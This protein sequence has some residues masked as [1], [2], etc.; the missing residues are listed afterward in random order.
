VGYLADRQGAWGRSARR[1]LPIHGYCGPNGSGKSMVMVYDTI[2]TLE[3]GRPVLSTVRLL[4]YRNPRPCDGGPS[5][6]DPENHEVERM[7]VDLRRSDPDDP[8]SPIIRTVVPTGI[9]DVHQQ[10][11]PLYVRFTDYGQL[12]SWRDGDILMDEVTGVAS[13][14][15]TSSMPVQVANYLVQ[16][17]RRNVA[18]RWSS[19]AWG[20]SDK[21]IREC[22]QG[23]T[24]CTAF[25]PKPAPVDP[26]TGQ[27]AMWLQRR[28]FYARTYDPTMMDEFD[29]HRADAI[30]PNAR[31]YLW[32]PGS[33]AFRAYST[34]D[35]VTALGWATESG[36]CM[37]CWGKRPIPKCTCPSTRGQHVHGAEAEVAAKPRTADVP[38]LVLA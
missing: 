8:T 19:P 14:R 26:K 32:G 9:F 3:S 10:A 1:S 7:S 4:D 29:A 22:S 12:L 34:L 2:P 31:Q 35:A 30:H 20:R 15:E 6:D 5:C 21:I 17:R 28:L 23:A 38:P 16:L 24:L 33:T 13:S 25:F 27:R 37:T 11:H 36:M 18:L